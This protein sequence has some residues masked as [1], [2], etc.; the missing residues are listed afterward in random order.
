MLKRF[1]LGM[2]GLLRV[3]ILLFKVLRH[4][5]LFAN[6]TNLIRVEGSDLQQQQQR[7]H[8]FIKPNICI[9]AIQHHLYHAQASSNQQQVKR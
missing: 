8:L 1:G 7:W 3:F 4:L 6:E 5:V 9:V 2:G